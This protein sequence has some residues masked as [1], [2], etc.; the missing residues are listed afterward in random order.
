MLKRYVQWVERYRWAIVIGSIVIACAGAAVA[1]RLSVLAD[2]SYLLPQSARSVKDLRAIEQRTRV[3]G[4]SMF[5]VQS[6]R[7]ESRRKA[8]VLAKDRITA[9]GPAWVASITFDHR[10]EHA[11]AWTNRWLGADAKD[12]AKARDALGARIAHAK[13]EANPLYISL[14]DDATSPAG[15]KQRDDLHE[16]E[17]KLRDAE[18]ERDDPGE[19][20]SKDGRVQT[21]IIHLGF[22][23][24]DVDKDRVFLAK[25]EAIAA[26]VH[27][28]LP[29]VTAGVAGDVP[30]SIAEHDAILNGMLRATL[31]TVV[32]VMIALIWYFRSALAIGALSWSL[33]VGTIL[34]FAVAKLTLGYL[35]AATAF[36]SSIVIGN[37]IN[38][39]ILVTA[40]YLEELR[41]GRSASE[42]L[43]AA[44]GRTIAGTF[45]AALTAAV[46]YA[47]LIIT[48]FRGFRHFG[49]IGGIGILL[50]WISGYVVLPA[51][52]AVAAKWIRPR[53][54]SAPGRWLGR[55][56]PR[57]LDVVV[58]I[59]LGVTVVAGVITARF[60]AGEPFETNF[61]NLRS[62]SEGIVEAQKWM[63]VVDQS[64]GQGLDSGFAIVVRDRGEVAPIE[65]K[66][67]A[68][69]AGRAQHDKLFDRVVS[70]DD[71]VPQDQDEK[72]RIL[73][74][75]RAML[76]GKEIEQLEDKERAELDRLRPPE[77]IAK[78]SDQD[79]PVEI[80]WP[81]IEADGTRGRILLASLGKGY[82]VWDT[83]DTTRWAAQV[84]ALGLPDE[85]HLGGASFVFADVIDGVLGDG[86]RATLAAA[87]G[88]ILIVLLVIGPN[89]FGMVTLACGASGTL[90]MLGI[91]AVAGLKVN[92]LDFVALPIT[93]GIGIEYAVNIVTRARQEGLDHG[94]EVVAS[95]GGAVVLCSYTTTVGYGSLLLSQNL[96][97][98]SFGVAAMLGEVT[99]LVVA[100]FLAPAL[101][102]LLA[103]RRAPAGTPII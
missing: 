35:N 55:L 45:T 5:V 102:A 48:I 100:L 33:T 16:L 74:E 61:K 43:E 14:E 26:A 93:I 34:T 12:L 88:A 32:L 31:V 47:S 10:V 44:V 83:R 97:I 6:E 101:L 53:G 77:V 19:Y 60:L 95:T 103:R 87:L 13:L 37:G 1:S 50:C 46:A 89:R 75:I 70:I 30:V 4:S 63:T 51:A 39:G 64:F 25:L 81:F 17:Q 86:P 15:G 36:L 59:T 67:R 99:C 62:H 49:I 98:R 40:R 24:G 94:R 79:I 41:A 66:L 54:N 57:R 72:I 58:I 20:V 78:L 29:D 91:S 56:L 76:S 22:S 90:L 96:G 92:F 3:V 82:E 18:R 84:R 42:A 28:E 68:V 8:A 52:L 2:F 73:G 7:P 69:D 65:A 80:A 23:S 27:A 9:L 85:V 21:M 11:F 71:L 38:V